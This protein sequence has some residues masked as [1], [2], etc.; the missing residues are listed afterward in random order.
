MINIFHFTYTFRFM[1]KHK[2]ISKEKSNRIRTHWNTNNLA[3]NSKSNTKETVFKI[4]CRLFKWCQRIVIMIHLSVVFY[5]I[6]S[7]IKYIFLPLVPS[8]NRN[9][10]IIFNTA[11]S[12]L[13]YF[14]ICGWKIKSRDMPTNSRKNFLDF[15]SLNVVF[16]C[17]KWSSTR[18]L[19]SETESTCCLASCWAA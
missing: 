8:L 12:F 17:H 13:R 18:L 10:V 19:S 3:K 11:K 16:L 14:G 9:W 15:L 6:C 7:I 4:F 1:M 5:P 2:L